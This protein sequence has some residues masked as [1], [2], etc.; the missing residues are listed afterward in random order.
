[1]T[2][3]LQRETL[4][5]PPADAPSRPRRRSW[6]GLVLACLAG[7]LFSSVIGYLVADQVTEHQHFARTRSALGLTRHQTAMVKHNL[8]VLVHDV[9]LLTAQVGK[10]SSTW[11]QD[12]A[13][14]QAAAT[15]LAVT[16]GDVSKQSSLIGPLHVCLGGVQQ[17]LNALAINDQRDAVSALNSVSTSC[18]SAGG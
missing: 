5:P 13:Q 4:A 14:L 3:I 18:A 11:K 10:D 17:A 7:A 15:A 6:T 9:S 2:D 12:E 16:Q 8:A 1:M